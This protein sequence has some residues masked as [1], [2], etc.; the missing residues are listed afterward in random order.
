MRPKTEGGKVVC[1]RKG[2]IRNVLLHAPQYLEDL[3]V[4]SSG[5]RWEDRGF[6]KEATRGVPP[7]MPQIPAAA[8]TAPRLD[9][10][11]GSA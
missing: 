7:I 6:L 10:V 1:S 8:V 9:V 2:S 4:G 3:F 11:G 5:F